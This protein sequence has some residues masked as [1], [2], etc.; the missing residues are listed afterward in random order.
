M[1]LFGTTAPILVDIN[2]ILQYVTLILLVSGYAKRNHR[3][4]HGYIMMSVFLITLGTTLVIMAPRL[5]GTIE[6][7]GPIIIGHALIGI[8]AMLF[9]TLFSFRFVTSTR[10]GKPL[11]CGTK[12]LMRL[13]F[14][15]W[16]FPVIFGTG[17]YLALYL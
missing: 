8:C 16:L 12:N 4:I 7:S 1:G 6:I 10:A 15:L 13:T 2:L 9:G 11:Q 3:K 14:I 5:L 17:T